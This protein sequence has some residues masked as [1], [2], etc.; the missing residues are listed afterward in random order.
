MRKPFF[1]L[2]AFIDDSAD[3]FDG[4]EPVFVLAGCIASAEDWDG[5]TAEWQERLDFVHPAKSFKMSEVAARWGV[6]DERVMFF[7]RVIEQYVW[8]VF[9]CVIPVSAYRGAIA[10]FPFPQFEPPTPYQLAFIAIVDRL[11]RSY[12][13]LGYEGRIKFVFDE[14]MNEDAKILARWDWILERLPEGT[15]NMVSR[16]PAFERDDEFLPLQA[17]DFI[18]WWCRRHWKDNPDNRVSLGGRYKWPFPW[19]A[20]RPLPFFELAYLEDDLLKVWWKAALTAL[21]HRGRQGPGTGRLEPYW[22]WRMPPAQPLGYSL[23]VWTRPFK[24]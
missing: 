18:A 5:F 2:T 23:P 12:E 7:Y 4:G 20:K 21:L 9:C 6:E 3:A 15:Q 8:S 1:V 16:T 19:A 24:K 22:R 17:A 11:C 10:K 13:E 14:Q